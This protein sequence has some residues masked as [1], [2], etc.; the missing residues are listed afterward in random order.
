VQYG[1]WECM[2]LFMQVASA[3]PC[4]M[5]S[6]PTSESVGTMMDFKTALPLTIAAE[7]G[8]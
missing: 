1:A 4:G 3:G 7:A 8:R 6:A 5:I 2:H